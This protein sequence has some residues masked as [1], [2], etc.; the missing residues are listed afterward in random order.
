M[1]E[2][3]AV[4]QERDWNISKITQN[5]YKIWTG[6]KNQQQEKCDKNISN[7]SNKNKSSSENKLKLP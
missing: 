5:L 3:Q 7:E 6:D 2:N 1:V 4:T